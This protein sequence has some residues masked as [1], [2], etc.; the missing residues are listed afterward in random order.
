M[1]ERQIN[2]EGVPELIV[3]AIESMAQTARR[4]ATNGG[5]KQRSRVELPVWHL[6]IKEPLKRE[7][8]YDD[9]N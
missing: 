9:S 6:G 7:D 4:R 2:L 8:Y 5:Q 1:A 3:R